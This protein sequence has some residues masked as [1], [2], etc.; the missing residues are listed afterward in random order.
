[1]IKHI[2]LDF[3][4][5]LMVSNKIFSK[6]RLDF[7]KKEFFQNISIDELSFQ[8][9]SIGD[10]SDTI[11]M[12]EGISIPSEVMYQRLFSKFDINIAT[13]QAEKIYNDLEVLFLN[14]PPIS[15]YDLDELK[16]SLKALRNKG[17]TTNISS[18]TAFI[19]GRTLRGVFKHYDLLDCFDFL[20][21]SDEINSSKPSSN[22]FKELERK[23]KNINVSKNNI[24][25]LGDSFEADV[26]GAEA[27]KIKSKLINIDNK[28]LIQLLIDLEN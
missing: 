21:F 11:N 3:W 4:N 25:H 24:L 10:E 19:K 20:I 13:T 28:K 15:I 12:K 17:Y 7:L 22:F 23:C 6:L 9:E 16:R 2:S 1:M 5:T 18:N 14:N 8:I 26:K 27:F